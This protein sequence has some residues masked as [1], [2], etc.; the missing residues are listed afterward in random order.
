MQLC[1][2]RLAKHPDIQETLKKEIKNGC[3]KESI[4]INDQT[5]LTLKFIRKNCLK[6]RAFVYEVL[7]FHTIGPQGGMRWMDKECVIKVGSFV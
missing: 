5:K 2:L 4:D 3:L 6:I 1:I 7:R